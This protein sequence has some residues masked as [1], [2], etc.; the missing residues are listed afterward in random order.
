MKK[1]QINYKEII[2]SIINDTA[3]EIDEFLKQN[4]EEIRERY[5]TGNPTTEEILNKFYM[6]KNRINA[7]LTL[8]I[9]LV[10]FL[11]WHKVP[12]PI[13]LYNIG[14][15]RS[16]ISISTGKTGLPLEGQ[17]IIQSELGKKAQDE[18]WGRVGKAIEQ[19]E[20]EAEKRWKKWEKNGGRKTRHNDMAKNLLDTM[21]ALKE[22]KVKPKHLRKALKKVAEKIDLSLVHGTPLKK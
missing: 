6:D 21:P 16:Y 5:G 2:A 4:G 7:A 13:L 9:L 15:L 19:A 12:L 17:K 8:R 20:K 14:V 3:K 10:D 11:H 22:A 1:H 18:R